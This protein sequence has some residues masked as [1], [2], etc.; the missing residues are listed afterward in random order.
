[1]SSLCCHRCGS[2]ALVL[3]EVFQSHARYDEGL[4][5]DQGAIH[6]HGEAVIS[7]GDIQPRLTEI[8]CE[9]CGHTWHPRR[10]FAGVEL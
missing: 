1:M 8:E 4:Y 7:P 3:I 5:L 10:R 6:A 9:G 2:A